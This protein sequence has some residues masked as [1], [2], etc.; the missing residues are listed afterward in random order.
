M[1]NLIHKMN[2]LNQSVMYQTNAIKISIY[3]KKVLGRKKI[4]F[5]SKLK[6]IFMLRRNN[7]RKIEC[8]FIYAGLLPGN[9]VMHFSDTIDLQYHR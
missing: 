3:G 8:R 7:P 2:K 6:S 1:N 9:F 4:I 5:E